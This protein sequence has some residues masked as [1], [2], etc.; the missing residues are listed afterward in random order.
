MFNILI[1]DDQ[2]HIRRLYEH[3]LEKNGYK[4]YCA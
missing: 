1:A 3:L 2:V 4:P